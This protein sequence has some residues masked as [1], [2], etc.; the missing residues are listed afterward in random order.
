MTVSTHSFAVSSSFNLFG[1]LPLI[2]LKCTLYIVC[3]RGDFKL[4]VD[5]GW[6]N[7]VLGN[8]K[9]LTCLFVCCVNWADCSLLHWYCWSSDL[10]RLLQHCGSE[11]SQKLK[12]CNSASWRKELLPELGFVVD[13]AMPIGGK[14]KWDP[15]WR[16]RQTREVDVA[17]V[18]DP[19]WRIIRW[20]HW[21]Y[22]SCKEILPGW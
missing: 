3:Q 21:L 20:P 6:N 2:A 10:E 4:I 19:H 1:S 9:T 7:N 18:T 11:L 14:R 5:P 17:S 15:P 16:K 12:T 8:G 13:Y 22:G